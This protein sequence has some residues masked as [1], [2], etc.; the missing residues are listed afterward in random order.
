MSTVVIT[1]NE[2]YDLVWSEPMLT[3]SKRYV[4]S[5]VGLRKICINMN[6]PLPRAGHWM[7]LQAGKKVPKEKLSENYSGKAEVK[8]ELREEGKQYNTGIYS[9][10]KRVQ[11]EIK[12][13]FEDHLKVSERLTSRDP[14]IIAAKQSLA[15]KNK[16]YRFEG[17]IETGRGIL[18]IQVSIAN[19]SRALRF[20]DCLLKVL[21]LRG[22]GIEVNSQGTHAIVDGEKIK[23]ICREKCKRV[24]TTK[25]SWNS[26]EF[27]ANGLLSFKTDG[28][29]SG[30]WVDG[31]KL[32]EEQI[33]AIIAKMEIS[34]KELHIAQNEH[35]AHMAKLDAERQK[36]LDIQERKDKEL[37][38]FKLLL[39]EANRWNNVQ[40]LRNYLE[41][42]ERKAKQA[43]TRTDE[44]DQWFDWAKKKTDWYDPFV[45]S[46]DELLNDIDKVSLTPRK[47]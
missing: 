16:A 41:A 29:H 17:L 32:I 5:D 9:E 40:L 14:L 31:N 7:K 12:A 27:H 26:Y 4:I 10:S 11:N 43:N 33:P 25:Y 19:I 18:D 15:Q 6:I 44:F 23:M 8:L 46:S 45:N 37:A 36:I 20:M 21:R 35:R 3:L 38:D 39:N 13:N 2:L 34:V 28:Y 1:R 22:H 47:V 42:S 24:I 30:E